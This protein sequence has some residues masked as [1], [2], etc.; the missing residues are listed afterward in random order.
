MAECVEANVVR[1]VLKEGQSAD[2][3]M[4]AK[5]IAQHQPQVLTI[6]QGETSSTVCNN[7]FATIEAAA[8]AHNCLSDRGCRLYLK[9]YGM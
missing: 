7:N 3:E 9:Y 5:Y 8:K 4:V 2:P 6:L 1:L